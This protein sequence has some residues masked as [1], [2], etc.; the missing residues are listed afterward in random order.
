MVRERTTRKICKTVTENKL[1]CLVKKIEYRFIWSSPNDLD[2]HGN[3]VR[4]EVYIIEDRT[5]VI[6]DRDI[7]YYV[8][9]ACLEYG[10]KV[11]HGTCKSLWKARQR[12]QALSEVLGGYIKTIVDTAPGYARRLRKVA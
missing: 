11:N 2:K 4:W 3:R 5:Y 1:D 12:Y 6:G 10:A 7:T 8:G 9:A